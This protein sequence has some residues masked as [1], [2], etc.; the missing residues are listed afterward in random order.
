[1]KLIV[2]REEEY[3]IYV[4]ENSKNDYSKAIVDYTEKWAGLM[5]EKV[6]QGA[7]IADIAK[8]TSHVADM[9]NITGFMYGCAVKALANFWKHGEELRQWH[10][11]DI[12]IRDEGEK[13]NES[14][15]VLNP[16][17]LN[18][19]GKMNTLRDE[20]EMAINRNSAEN[21][22]NTPDFILAEYLADCLATFDK[23][24]RAREKWFGKELSIGGR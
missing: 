3:Q 10:N 17:I 8:T 12:Q 18:K 19:G 1:M 22:S 24:S 20:I 13:A 23:A 16:A 4:G 14:G 6:A 11:L 21:G 15:G 7:K 5:E 9:D 2:G